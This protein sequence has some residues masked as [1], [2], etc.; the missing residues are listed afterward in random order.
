[1]NMNLG[2]SAGVSHLRGGGG[3][4]GSGSGG[5]AT[6][7]R[8]LC[9]YVDVVGDGGSGLSS[10]SFGGGFPRP[11]HDDTDD[12]TDG[13][14]MG[15]STS[16]GDSTL[17]CTACVQR[18][19]RPYW[20]RHERALDDHAA[21]RERCDRGLR[22]LGGGDGGDGDV[23]SDPHRWADLRA[24]SEGL[25]A[26]LAHLREECG[27]TAVRVASLAVE[28]DS[29]REEAGGTVAAP[30]PGLG[31]ADLSR[32]EAS[33]LQGSMADAI[34]G[35]ASHVRALRF[36]WARR[37]LAMHR[38]DID[39]DDVKLTPLQ[40]RRQETQPGQ[41]LQRRARGIAKIAGL[42]LP[43]AGPELY[44]VLPPRELQSALRLVAMVT[45]TVARCLGIVL[46][47]PILLTLSTGPS[48]EG[49]ITEM[50]AEEDLTRR[51]RGAA[52][53][54]E[55]GAASSGTTSHPHHGFFQ[56]SHHGAAGGAAAPLGSTSTSSLMS[57]MDGSYWTNKAKKALAKA[58][59]QQQPVEKATAAGSGGGVSGVSGTATF[60]PPSTDATIVAQRLEHATAAILADDAS[61]HSSKFALS[62]E[63]MHSDDFAVALQL[64]QNNVI[65]LCIRAG[66]PV[67]KLWPAEAMLFNLK[68]L[69]EFCQQ[70]TAVAF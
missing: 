30:S 37:V 17:R 11:G 67:S 24:E 3:R 45:S 26:R 34:G 65:V 16:G 35:A 56:S 33:V 7:R 39:P 55:E 61:A 68:E 18:V 23:L 58:T 69:D 38:L 20:D 14:G 63:S 12:D 49:D 51:R 44:G 43:N 48:G 21:A 57:F 28:N 4:S 52:R 41:Q 22:R 53:G 66:V 60:I 64:L 54:N 13:T 59:G 40:R 29:L 32:L 15:L 50:V 6:V 5:V 9:H 19:L 31:R 10:S 70:Q 1:M 8:C 27:E 47:H 2:G 42:P 25:R 36:Q 62:A 46:P